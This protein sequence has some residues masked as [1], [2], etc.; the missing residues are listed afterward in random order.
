MYLWIV[1]FEG[2][3]AVTC[4]NNGAER[5][6]P[7][8][9]LARAKRPRSSGDDPLSASPISLLHLNRSSKVVSD[10]YFCEISLP[11]LGKH[12]SA[13]G[14]SGKSLRVLS[15]LDFPVWVFAIASSTLSA[16]RGT[17]RPNPGRIFSTGG[18]PFSIVRV[19]IKELGSERWGVP[20]EEETKRKEGHH[21]LEGGKKA[22]RGAQAACETV[23][24]REWSWSAVLDYCLE[25]G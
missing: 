11:C 2:L 23:E 16:S 5:C 15:H 4:L 22:N 8:Q 21:V 10:H 25:T 1:S 24:R 20:V 19:C 14:P 6:C 7:F 12:Q 18:P 3:L 9:Q 17:L 13:L